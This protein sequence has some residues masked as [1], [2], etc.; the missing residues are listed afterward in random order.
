[1]TEQVFY[2]NGVVSVTNA[3]CILGGKTIPVRS[4][5]AV[6][7]LVE[8]PSR[9]FPILLVIIGIVLICF[10]AW[11]FGIILAAAG[12]AWLYFQKNTYY[13]HIET[14]AGSSNAYSS[15]DSAHIQEIVDALN[16]AIISQSK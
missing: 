7:M 16:D 5:N 6:S 13:V 4:I 1:M 9:L 11:L 14:A 15:K 8:S 10:K 2:D 3:R 12:G